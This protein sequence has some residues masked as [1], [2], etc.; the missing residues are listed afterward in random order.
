MK[1]KLLFAALLACVTLGWV[2][3]SDSDSG[4]DGGD[5][6]TT[7]KDPEMKLY[8]MKLTVESVTDESGNEVPT[9]IEEIETTE[10]GHY[11]VKMRREPFLSS[12]PVKGISA[13]PVYFKYAVGDYTVSGGVYTL[14]NFGTLRITKEN[15]NSVEFILKLDGSN[16]TLTVKA[17]KMKP[18]ASGTNTN[19]LCR[20]W[21]VKSTQ[22]QV[23]ENPG[24]T[25]GHRFSGCDLNEIARYLE[26]KGA[27]VE[28]EFDANHSVKNIQFTQAGTYQIYYANGKLDIGKWKWDNQTAGTLS[29]V[30]DSPEMGNSFWNGKAK[31]EF[32]EKVYLTFNALFT[33]GNKR[34]DVDAV[35]ELAE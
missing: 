3:C 11:T 32:E 6:K 27:R 12:K 4:E 33:S 21:K 29:Y 23:K 31:V 34:Y 26:D 19:Y 10:S 16:Q 14:K 8:A 7:L 18:V 2:S 22:L 35:C 9:D 24:A 25:Y 15:G 28:D 17:T 13:S 20:T 1:K 30:W 5:P